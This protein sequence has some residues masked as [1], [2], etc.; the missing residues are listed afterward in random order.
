MTE[1]ARIRVCF[2]SPKAYP[3][4]NPAVEKVFGGAEVDLYLLATELAR[5]ER[6]DVRF[7]IADYGQPD[8]E[9]RQGVTLFKSVKTDR[10]MIAEG[11]KVW[12]ALQRADA[13]SY[14][15]EACSLGT[16]LIAAFCRRKR[17][18]FVYRTA[19][20][21]EADGTYA[22]N[23]RF[24]GIFV[25]WAFRNASVLIVQN[26]QDAVNMRQQIGR[27]ARVIRNAC[28]ISVLNETEKAGVLWV[29]RSEQVKRPDLFLRLAAELPHIPFTMICQQATG[30]DKYGQLVQ[31]ARTIPNLTFIERVPFAEI[32]SY[33]ERASVFVNTSDSEG[34]PNTFVQ[35]CK[36]ATAILSLNVNPDNF[37]T[38]H[39][40][41]C[42]TENDWKLLIKTLDGWIATRQDRQL[43]QNGLEYVR[44]HHDLN[45]IIGEYK[46]IFVRVIDQ[47]RHG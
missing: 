24:R 16:W 45:K 39:R 23:K 10:F 1:S 4:F 12:R 18:A 38:E 43:G 15:H 25:R 40:C 34:F 47:T 46:D 44:A 20:S 17:R 41:G 31:H 35:A 36:A 27:E 7:V 3:L 13:D 29:G 32:D 6:F 14:M 2:V 30:D 37:L 19:S 28:R 5:D 8:G 33:F 22:R 21:Q 26:E 9:K 42:C 11:W